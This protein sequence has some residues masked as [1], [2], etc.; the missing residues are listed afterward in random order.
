MMLSNLWIKINVQASYDFFLLALVCSF[1][2]TCNVSLFE[3]C[4]ISTCVHTIRNIM[5]CIHH[6]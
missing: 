5:G 1:V 3:F 4:T 2:C 6:E